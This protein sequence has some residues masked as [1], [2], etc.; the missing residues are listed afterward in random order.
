MNQHRAPDFGPATPRT[1]A[2][3]GWMIRL[4]PVFIA[5]A[6]ALALWWG[7]DRREAAYGPQTPIDRLIEGIE[8]GDASAAS[9]L[10]RRGQAWSDVAPHVAGMLVHPS[11]RVRTVACELLAGRAAEGDVD[12]LGALVARASDRDWRV[13]AAAFR[14]LDAMRAF[15][16][17]LPARD[18]PLA[19]RERLLIDWL[20][21]DGRAG[22]VPWLAELCEVYAGAGPIVVGRPMTG[23]CVVCHVGDRDRRVNAHSCRDC[24]EAEHREWSGSAH[25]QSLSHLRLN[26]VNPVTRQLERFGFG[27]VGGLDCTACHR[28]E[29]RHEAAA[30]AIT[31]S[32]C[33]HVFARDVVGDAACA[34][35]HGE[36]VR[37]WRGWSGSARPVAVDWPPGALEWSTRT[38]VATCVACHMPARDTAGGRG[39]SH[40]FVARR[41]SQFIASGVRLTAR[42]PD[43]RAADTVVRIELTNLAGHAFPTGTRRRAIRVLVYTD[44]NRDPIEVAQLVPD[45]AG[46]LDPALEPA[47]AP[48][49][50]RRY[51]F[52]APPGARRVEVRLEY[53]R[54]RFDAA[55]LRYE[56][57]SSAVRLPGW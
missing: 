43:P 54:D 8:R 2:T 25:A 22:D 12:A 17:T 9:A 27:A 51:E 55:S 15:D 36:T 19:D 7:L 31:D 32:G 10:R 21:A 39:R 48:A 38:P 47:L 28:I 18:T 37:Q 24:H 14:A 3:A 5:T 53:V 50:Q 41:D 11:P 57:A 40:A 1:T 4:L 16:E 13:R 20:R 52:A 6:L 49:E 33:V 34:S 45:R 30:A 42:A 23:Q 35:C 46:N 29:R 26:T 56:F 44:S